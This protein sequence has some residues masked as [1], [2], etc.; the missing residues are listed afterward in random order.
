MTFAEPERK[1]NNS[2]T[3]CQIQWHSILRTHMMEEEKQLQFSLISTHVHSPV[4]TQTDV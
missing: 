1:F 4:H 2:S 3:Y